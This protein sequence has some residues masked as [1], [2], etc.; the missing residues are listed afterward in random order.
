MDPLPPSFP[1]LTKKTASFKFKGQFCLFLRTDF[2]A[3]LRTFLHSGAKQ[4]VRSKIVKRSPFSG[5]LV[6]SRWSLLS[7]CLGYF[8]GHFL[9]E[10]LLPDVQSCGMNSCPPFREFMED[11]F[12]LERDAGVS[13]WIFVE[14]EICREKLNP[15]PW[16]DLLW[17]SQEFICQWAKSEQKCLA[18]I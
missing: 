7:W 12:S 18:Y 10:I 13:H 5:S 6:K 4:G 14:G 2:L 17:S 3:L 8:L 15:V 11:R 9:P 16:T 1:N